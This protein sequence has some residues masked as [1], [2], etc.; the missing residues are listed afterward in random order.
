MFE[1]IE[2]KFM[3]HGHS[4]LEN[5]RNFALIEK[6]KKSSTVLLLEDWA[7]VI[8]ASGPTWSSTSKVA[9]VEQ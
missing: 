4:Y 9:G 7:K 6:R 8:E 2:H 1:S 5:D 3:V